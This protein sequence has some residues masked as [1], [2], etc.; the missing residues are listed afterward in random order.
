MLLLQYLYFCII[1]VQNTNI[2]IS[3]LSN[4]PG[5]NVC[6]HA[7]IKCRSILFQNL[8]V[9]FSMRFIF[10]WKSVLV[11]KKFVFYELVHPACSCYIIVITGVNISY[12]CKIRIKENIGC[13]Y[14]KLFKS[15]DMLRL[16]WILL[17]FFFSA[18]NLTMKD[19]IFFQN[20][21]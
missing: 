21:Y 14:L 3:C 17:G 4:K 9:F 7:C 6:L 13:F 11:L 5:F 10:T 12:R 8:F 1:F 19:I 2:K 20:L 18:N 15:L 16:D